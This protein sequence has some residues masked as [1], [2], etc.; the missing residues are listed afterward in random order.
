MVELIGFA[1]WLFALWASGVGVGIVAS[2]WRSPSRSRDKQDD[3]II[4][5]IRRQRGIQITPT[6]D[7][8]GNES[9]QI[10][11]DAVPLFFQAPTRKEHL[12]VGLGVGSMGIATVE[13]NYDGILSG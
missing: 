2:L 7:K 11:F 9:V 13:R 8:D 5:N 4:R 10:S 3:L 12:R 6:R 1:A